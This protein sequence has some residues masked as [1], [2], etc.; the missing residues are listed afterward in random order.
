MYHF[1]NFWN[2]DLK[3]KHGKHKT[4]LRAWK[5]IETFK[6][7]A[8]GAGNVAWSIGGYPIVFIFKR[9]VKTIQLAMESTQRVVLF[10][11]LLH[12]GY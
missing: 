7:R 11:S 4:G 2:F 5:V 3:Y 10:F 1:Q 8:P 12:G 9:Y 6:K